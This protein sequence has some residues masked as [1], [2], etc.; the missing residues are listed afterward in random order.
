MAERKAFIL[1]IIGIFLVAAFVYGKD[2]DKTSRELPKE[3]AG[4]DGTPML[5]IPA[6]EFQMGSH[7]GSGDEKPVH[8]LY[9]DAFY[10]DKYEVTN[11]Q[12]AR[13]LN[14]SRNVRDT[15]EKYGRKVRNS[16]RKILIYTDGNSPIEKV[17]DTF[18]LK[19]GYENYPVHVTWFGAAAYAHHYGKRLPTEAEWEKAARGGLAGK[20]YPW[21]DA[22]PDGTQCNFADRNTSGGWLG[23]WSD[24]NA[25]DGYTGTAPV[26]C[27]TP[28]GYG[29]YDMAGNVW[30]WCSDWYGYYPRSYVKSPVGSDSGTR[31]VLRGGSWNNIPDHLR[32]TYRYSRGP[33]D[34]TSYIGF[35]CARDAVL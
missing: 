10:M 4:K 24:R 2:A 29:L 18:V 16:D 11:A 14:E 26:G 32:V 22:E 17:E 1:F 33:E 28:N 19:A 15:H 5:L 34:S 31:R 6:G 20:K 8:T 30:E 13:F 12:Y 3:I 25:N 21:G 35:R 27:Y 9:T 7:D 23:E